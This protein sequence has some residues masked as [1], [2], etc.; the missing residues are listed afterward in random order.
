MSRKNT[1][2]I[3]SHATSDVDKAAEKQCDCFIEVKY[4]CMVY[5]VLPMAPAERSMMAWTTGCG[6]MV[7]KRL[8]E[9]VSFFLSFSYLVKKINKI[10]K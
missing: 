6:A 7:S 10:K 3:K 1:G 4:P 5:T 8:S 9:E 2:V